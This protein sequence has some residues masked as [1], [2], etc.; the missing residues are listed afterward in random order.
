MPISTFDA[1]LNE[2]FDISTGGVTRSS[3]P[4]NGKNLYFVGGI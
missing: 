2:P 1:D 4:L 3:P